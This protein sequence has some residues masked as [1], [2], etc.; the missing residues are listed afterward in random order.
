MM[1]LRGG[2]WL[3]GRDFA[4]CAGRYGYHPNDRDFNVGF[5]CVRT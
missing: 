4:R 1:V 3:N 5:R 2:C